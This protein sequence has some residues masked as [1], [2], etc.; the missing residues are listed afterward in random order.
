M[1]KKI[2]IANRGEI[3]VRVIRACKEWG[4]STVA[5]HSDVDRESMHV[6]L[7]DESVCVGP[8]QPANSYL[9]IPAIMSAIELTNSEAVHPGY[10]FLSENF[11]FAK[12]LEEN[13]IKFIGP[14]SKLIRMMGDKI[15]AKKIAKENGLP[16]IE[17]SD[18]GISNIK[19]AKEICTKIGFPVLIKAAGGG[20][21]KGMKIVY[22]ETKFEELFLAAKSEAKKFFAND[23]VYI[24]K[25]FQDPRHIEVQVLS[26]KNR[27]V[28][29][30]ERDC[31]IQRRHQK[32]IE[33]T[34][35]PILNN[36]IR[37]DLFTKTVNMVSKIGY[38]GAGTVEFIYE[39]GKFYFLEMNTRV[40][41]EH[42][43]TEMVT[44]IDIIKEQI[45]IAYT[46]NTALEQKDIV[47][48]GHAIECRINAE[49]ASKNFQPSPGKITMCHQPSGFRTRVDGAIYQGYKVTP[50]YD[51][52]ICKLICHGRNREEAIQRMMRSL[53]E[54]VIEGI[55]TTIDL[56]K[57]LLG[58]KK[59]LNSDFNV[60]W[61]DK[62]KVI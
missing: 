54:F 47:P 56:H 24:E 8:H 13:N 37:E 14:S 61:L 16:V 22:D 4:I 52:M 7:A 42:P 19:Q 48:R 27:T 9:N 40:Q 60:S 57:K 15:Q 30:H 31:S 53:D 18:G 26:G 20:G 28:H 29:L 11:N 38:E 45:W 34:P 46:G 10:G 23:E 5:I 59:F 58:H 49:D 33:E 21:G 62:E 12:I 50:F 35:S 36:E 51:S 3:A 25:F 17:G 39:N 32:L 2:L 43:V 44:G 41:V 55:T 6:K 1:F